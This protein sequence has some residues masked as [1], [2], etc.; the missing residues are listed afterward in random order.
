[1]QKNGRNV[2]KEAAGVGSASQWKT[3]TAQSPLDGWCGEDIIIYDV[4]L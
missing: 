2:T 4:Y 1:M 3:R